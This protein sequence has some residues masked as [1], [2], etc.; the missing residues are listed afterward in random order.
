[1]ADSGKTVDG[2]AHVLIRAAQEGDFDFVSNLMTEYLA[3]WYGGDHVAY[4]R[5]IFD[6]HM[7]GGADHVG[8]FSAEQH[9]F[10]LEVNSERAGLLHL[11]IKRQGTAKISPLIVDRRF[12]GQ[13]RGLGSRLLRHAE[14]FA[15][16]RGSRQIYA[17]VAHQNSA[18]F[19]FFRHMGYYMAGTSEGHYK[20]GVTEVMIY[21]PLDDI[22]SAEAEDRLHISVVQFDEDAHGEQVR[23]LIL[24]KLAPDFNG[25][26]DSWVDALYAGYSRRHLREV[27][28]KYKLIYVAVDG[29]GT[30]LGVVGC[31]PKKGEPIKLMPC[32][33]RTPEAFAALLIDVPFMLKEYGRKL[34]IHCVPTVSEIMVLER[35]GWLLNAIM[36][37][38]YHPNVAAQ[39][40]GNSLEGPMN[41]NMR[42]KGPLL[43]QIKDG[44]KTLEV[45]VG[46]P[47]I[48]QIR[49]GDH[50]DMM[51]ERLS[52]TVR[53]KEVRCY[54]TFSAMFECEDYHL[55]APGMSSSAVRA[56]LYRIYPAD[57]ERLGIYVLD[58]ERV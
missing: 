12:S 23:Q 26:D 6:A 29:T 18:A 28:A 34:Y 17:T 48:T 36:P 38:A 32:V 9:M 58:I 24:E 52:C 20:T 10:I 3:Q 42:V 1:M 25:V 16:E 50:I 43:Q 19:G 31:T 49:A 51:S 40:W 14:E 54:Q 4:A 8:H 45:R 5:R 11:V 15:R 46:Y 13:H 30:V 55:I 21:K 35:L 37:A 44:V 27:N 56:L 47:N 57:K 7:A 41:R 53:V 2:T 33:A 39:Q 22:K